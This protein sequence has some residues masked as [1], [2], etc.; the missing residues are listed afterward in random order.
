MTHQLICIAEE[1]RL[2][3]TRW[4]HGDDHR[5]ATLFQKAWKWVP[6]A[7]RSL[8][9]QYW[10]HLGYA[11]SLVCGESHPAGP[12]ASSPRIELV[13]GWKDRDT[14]VPAAQGR[15]G[16]QT[17]AGEVF[18]CGYLLRFRAW[19]IDLMPPEVVQDVVVQQLAHCWLYA[20]SVL[21]RA[22][23]CWELTR[24]EK[25]AAE[26]MRSWG[27]NPELAARWFAQADRAV[28]GFQAP[29]IGEIVRNPVFV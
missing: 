12:G 17:F 19:C 10:S 1:A 14:I 27:G 11:H 9:T 7:K 29:P 3:L 23:R 22:R 18:A 15:F 28:A 6:S 26:V 4:G 8:L 24:L 21:H 13:S 5:F 25:E 2:Y 20:D 16:S